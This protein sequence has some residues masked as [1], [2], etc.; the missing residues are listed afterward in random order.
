MGRIPSNF[1]ESGDPTFVTAIFMF[2]SFPWR[3]DSATARVHTPQGKL[4]NLRGRE[5]GATAVGQIM[6][7]VKKKGRRKGK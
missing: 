5:T 4:L 7:T 6:T 2:S 1:G 3:S